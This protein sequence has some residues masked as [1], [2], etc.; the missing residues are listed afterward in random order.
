MIKTIGGDMSEKEVEERIDQCIADIIQDTF[1]KDWK[2][3]LMAIRNAADVVESSAAYQLQVA[4]DEGIT[5]EADRVN[6]R[7][8]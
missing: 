2:H 8:K 7:K 6:R 4:K 3:L 5:N 1:P